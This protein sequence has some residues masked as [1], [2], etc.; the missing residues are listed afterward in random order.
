MFTVLMI[1][2]IIFCWFLVPYATVFG[3]IGVWI[4]GGVGAFVGIIIG[5]MCQ[6]Y[7]N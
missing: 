5:L 1:L 7:T 3:L 6:A 4:G 2:G